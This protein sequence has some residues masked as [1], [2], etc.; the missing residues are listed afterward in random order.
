[1]FIAPTGGMLRRKVNDVF[2][3]LDIE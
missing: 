2:P 1:V 3:V